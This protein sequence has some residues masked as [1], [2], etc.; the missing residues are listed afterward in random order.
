MSILAR[1]RS[2]AALHP[3]L[4]LATVVALAVF[5]MLDLWSRAERLDTARQRWGETTTVWVAAV[6]LAPGD[7]MAA[8]AQQYPLALV[9]PSHLTRDPTGLVAVQHLGR[10]DVVREVDVAR[11][12]LD[13][14]PQEWRGVSVAFDPTRT[15][16]GPG[17]RVDVVAA[18]AL[19]VSGAV[20]VALA[21]AAVVVGVP[22]DVAPAVADAALLGDATLVVRAD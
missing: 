6:D 13:L 8:E 19:L 18:G 1:A 7:A 10:G 15:L 21:D 14:L 9:S 3:R 17:T 5:V 4:T 22:A 2:W 11:S 16:L 12:G 20:V